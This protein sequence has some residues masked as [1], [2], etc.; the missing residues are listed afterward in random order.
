MNISEKDIDRF[1]KNVTFPENRIGGC[2]LWKGSPDSRGYGR[3]W[4]DGRRMTAHRVSFGIA[5][6]LQDDLHVLHHCDTPLCVNPTHLYQGT[7]ADNM[8]DTAIRHR[9]DNHGIKNPRA[10]LTEEQVAYIRSSK[11]VLRI[12]AEELGVGI[13]TVWSA[14]TG[15][16]W[17]HLNG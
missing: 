1:L 7:H 5:K 3:F 14:K 2:W 9:R 4:F 10:K 17:A 15:P 11:K 8:R 12:L 6:H 13:S 16:N